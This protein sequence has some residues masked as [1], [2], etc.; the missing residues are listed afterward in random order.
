MTVSRCT[1]QEVIKKK[2]ETEDIKDRKKSRRPTKL[3]K[4]D[5]KYLKITSLRNRTKSCQEL[6]LDLAQTSHTQAHSSTARRALVKE[7]LYGR[8]ARR[9]PYLRQA[10]KKNDLKLPKNTRN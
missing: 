4:S 8:V 3:T 2:K 1:V 9:K 6:G 5:C 7:G 10:N